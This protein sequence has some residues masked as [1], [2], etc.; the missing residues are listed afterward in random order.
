MSTESR[1]LGMT[2]HPALTV[3]SSDGLISEERFVSY[4]EQ[5]VAYG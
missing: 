4:V 2:R 1:V 5:I 3:S